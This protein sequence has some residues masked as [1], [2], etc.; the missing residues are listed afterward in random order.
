MQIIFD[1]HVLCNYFNLPKLKKKNIHGA[2]SKTNF[3]FFL[4]NSDTF[5]HYTI[6]Q[7]TKVYSMEITS[8]I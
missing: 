7:C 6:C 4:L 2:A 3:E 1:V 8:K 5:G